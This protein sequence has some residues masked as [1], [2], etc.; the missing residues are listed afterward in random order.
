MLNIN[1]NRFIIELLISFCKVIFMIPHNHTGPL[2][3]WFNYYRS[4]LF[5][6]FWGLPFLLSKVITLVSPDRKENSSCSILHKNSSTHESPAG[7]FQVD[8]A[9]V[10]FFYQQSLCNKQ[11]Y[12]F[13][14]MNCTTETAKKLKTE[15]LKYKNNIYTKN[16]QCLCSRKVENL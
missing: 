7:G 5:K 14:Y 10:I 15:P 2:I 8:L 4:V 9:L 12:Q 6:I 13:W 16:L 3:Y 11:P 1:V